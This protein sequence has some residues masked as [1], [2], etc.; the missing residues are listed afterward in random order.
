MFTTLWNLIIGLG[1][2]LIKVITKVLEMMRD[3]QLMD[4]GKALAKAEQDKKEA[5]QAKIELEI[6]REQTEILLADTSKDDLTKKLE[7]GKF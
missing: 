2:G 4:Q 6:N 5:A 3:K 7:D 1:G